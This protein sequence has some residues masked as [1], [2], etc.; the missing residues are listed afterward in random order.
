[1]NR[2]VAAGLCSALAACGEQRLDS[3]ELEVATRAVV[4]APSRAM[5]VP[6]PGGPAIVAVT[7]RS[8]DNAISQ[9]IRLATRGA[10][11]GENAIHVTFFTAADVVDSEG[12]KGNLLKM[13]AFE[14]D[15]ILREMEERLPGVAMAPSAV[16]VQNKYGPFSYAFGRGVGGEACL[17]AWQKL[18]RAD[19]IFLPKSGAIT[20]RIRLCDP[21]ATEASL[22]RIAYGYTIS[23][24]LSRPGWRPVD[25]APP[26]APRLGD[27]GSPIYPVAQPG[28]WDAPE[29]AVSVRAKPGS[30][31]VAR[32]A[33]PMEP[34]APDRRLEGYPVVPPPST[35]P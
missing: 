1:M 23:A 4:V 9:E 21:R 13:P 25:D 18:A 14:D 12:V 24:S 31:P 3:S 32:R 11:P 34:A 6:P 2:V 28:A 33:E 8:Y 5:A 29:P 10:T 30:R 22:L 35:N 19:S 27:A 7:Q 20:I 26:P 17:Y 16:F 15:A